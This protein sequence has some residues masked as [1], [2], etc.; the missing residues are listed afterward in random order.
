MTITKLATGSVFVG[1]LPEGCKLC[2]RGLKSIIFVTGLCPASCFYC[3]IS[4]ERKRD[5]TYVNEKRVSNL[6]EIIVEIIRSASLGASLTGGDPLVRLNRTLAIIESLKRF[7]GKN[8]HIHLYTSG[9]GLTIE[10]LERLERVGLDEI[11]VHP[12]SQVLNRLKT[13]VEASHIDFG[14]EI[15]MLPHSVKK[16]LDLIRYFDKIGIKFVNLNEL[17]F[18]ETNAL[19]LLERGYEMNNNYISAKYSKE[20]AT[21][22]INLVAKEGLSISVHFCPVKVKDVYQTSLRLFRRANIVAL[23]FEKVTDEGTIINLE[24]KTREYLIRYLPKG[25]VK[26]LDKETYLTGIDYIDVI[27]DNIDR[28]EIFIREEL[29]SSD[30]L[31]VEKENVE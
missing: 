13:L 22:V 29:A 11:R 14:I 19:A 8:F 23:P 30:R 28:A 1:K 4:K 2:Q 16:T 18:S 7:F 6:N 26:K 9:I 10:V 25:L 15:P 5:D 17:E 3:P 31:L 24:V 12:T 27:R 21:K 20:D